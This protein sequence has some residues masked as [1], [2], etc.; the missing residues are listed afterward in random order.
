MSC[1]YRK[2]PQEIILLSLNDALLIQRVKVAAVF[3]ISLK[4]A[5]VGISAVRLVTPIIITLS[6][7]TE[8]TLLPH[9]D[10]LGVTF[11]SKVCFESIFDRFPE[12]LLKG[13]VS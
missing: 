2:H 11:N 5:N 3:R 9:F 1:D 7:G 10:I 8:L 12:Q 13:L 4:S 6:P